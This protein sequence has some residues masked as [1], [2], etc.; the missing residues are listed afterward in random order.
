[1]ELAWT[2]SG[3]HYKLPSTNEDAMRNTIHAAE[4]LRSRNMQESGF[5]HP[6]GNL[7]FPKTG[8]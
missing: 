2:W 1:M 6:Y 8:I 5:E 3:G 4:T 7:F